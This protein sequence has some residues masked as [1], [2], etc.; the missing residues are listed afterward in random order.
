MVSPQVELQA[1]FRSLPGCPPITGD[2]CNFEIHTKSVLF[3]LLLSLS[4][5][6]F[7]SDHT[8]CYYLII[9]C[10]LTES[11]ISI[12]IHFTASIHNNVQIKCRCLKFIV[13]TSNRSIYK[14]FCGASICFFPPSIFF[15]NRALILFYF[16][17]M[18]TY[19]PSI[20]F[21]RHTH[22]TPTCKS[23]VSWIS[24]LT[25]GGLRLNLNVMSGWS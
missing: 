3:R 25:V 8:A 18:T 11:I 23:P 16:W 12:S 5:V 24:I 22:S 13:W 20:C 1:R 21:E 7:V 4:L 2:H 6:G 17:T 19:S 9:K 14:Y 10:A 15:F